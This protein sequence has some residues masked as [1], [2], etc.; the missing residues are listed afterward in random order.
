MDGKALIDEVNDLLH[1]AIENEE[2]DTIAGW[3]LT[4]KMELKNGDILKTEGCEFKILDAE[5]HHIR[6]I[7]VK[8]RIF[9]T[10]AVGRGCFSSM[11]VPYFNK[12]DIYSKIRGYI[13]GKS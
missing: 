11:A 9:K 2:V 1:I 7:E 3:L 8:K 6:F 4:Q 10:A 5:D 12:M 13:Y